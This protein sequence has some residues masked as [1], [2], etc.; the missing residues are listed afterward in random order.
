MTEIKIYTD[1]GCIGNPGPGGWAFVTVQD[2]R[3]EHENGAIAGTTNNRMELTAVIRA[4]GK[5]K[6]E[7]TSRSPVHVE[8]YTDSQYVRNGI[9]VWMK[10]WVRNGWRTA[11]KQPVKNQDLWMELSRLNDSLS[12][13]WHWLKGHAGNPMNELCD[14]LV[15]EAIDAL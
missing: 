2:G 6:E 15:H 9:T 7:V 8:L 14:R 10:N 13:E 12:V 4:L 5:V 1:G 3:I 11:G